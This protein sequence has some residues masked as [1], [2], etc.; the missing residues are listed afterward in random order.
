[1]AAAGEPE[2]R[3]RL[4]LF[5]ASGVAAVAI[6]FRL[7]A[8]EQAEPWIVHGGY[9]YILG[10]FAAAL[11]FA[12]RV[13]A[14]RPEAWRPWLRRP[15]AD[16]AVLA[17]GLAVAIGSDQFAHKVL[18]DE[19]VLQGTAW[20]L[21]ATKEVG[22]P[23]RAYEFAGTW[24]ATDAFLD[25]RPF[26]F[27]FVVSLVHDLTGFRQE[28]AFVVN[29]ACAAICLGLTLWL[30]RA[31]TGRAGAARI[32]V[33]LLATLP[34]FGQNATGASMEI[35]NLAMIAATLV[36]ATLYLR[37]PDDDRLAL[38][39]LTAVLLAQSRYES[40]IFVVPVA[41]AVAIGWARAGRILLP[42]P[43]LVA[44]LLLVPY[45]WHNRYVDTKPVLWQLR[46]GDT[47]R[48]GLHYL[49]GNLEGARNF[50]FSVSPGQ[51]ASL[52]L[53]LAGLGG[54]GWALWRW[55]RRSREAG[56]GW[57]RWRPEETA[58]ALVGAGIAANV[59]MLLFYYWS[60]FDEP[61][62]ARFALPF[63][64]LLAVAGGWVVGRAADRFRKA[65][66]AAALGL[67]AWVAVWGAPAYARRLYTLENQVMHETDWELELAMSRPGPVLAI[68]NKATMPFLLRRIPAINTSMAG[69][70]ASR[71]AWHLR[72]GTF[73][74]VIVA[75]V[76]RPTS[77]QGDAGVEPGDVLP[78]EF[79]LE[80]ID[81]KR[82]GTRWIR[83][84]RVVSID[85]V[86]AAPAAPVS[87]GQ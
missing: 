20:H 87:G 43:A 39:V 77:A 59:A 51:P 16:G 55:T 84:S 70:R 32:A 52:A 26:F 35:H 41:A 33:L 49:P 13:L 8:P 76:V 78:P 15:G 42:W 3:R 63:C 46:E 75:Q 28:N 60:R 82:F 34:L 38:L 24:L 10:V 65:T 14:A 25:K 80:T 66:A 69:A 6:G 29:V 1:M 11:V 23:V 2:T 22:T 30:V 53:S 27:T 45:A 4:L 79:K 36:A 12:G 40:V 81:R 5:G 86:P 50:F 74:E 44:P 21:H 71:I 64:F 83:V 47:G 58:V 18:F 37:A 56:G 67:A 61:I 57:A 73:R 72:Q 31:L 85:P 48:F 68:T 62:T 17:L 9:Y 7:V 19:Y 54:L